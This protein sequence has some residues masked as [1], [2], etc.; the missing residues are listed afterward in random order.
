MQ[1]LG[2]LGGPTGWARWVNDAG[3][4]TGNADLPRQ[5]NSRP[6][7]HAFLWKNGS[8]TDLVPVEGALCS[9]GVSIN[10]REQV[11]GSIGNCRGHQLGAMLWE[12]GSAVDLNTLVAP[13][14]LHLTEAEYIS[15]RGEIVAFAVLPNSNQHVVLMEPTHRFATAQGSTIPTGGR[16]STA[17]FTVWFDSSA[18]GQG[19]VLFGS[20][21]GCS[22]LVETATQD[23]GAGTTS[24][25]VMVTGND[26]PGSV[27]D[28]G[29]MPG[30]TYWYEV[31]TVT[32]SGTEI[33]TNGGKC[34][35]VSIPATE[36]ER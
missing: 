10:N 33:D 6:T 31:A 3:E 15:D 22:G 30:V 27:G 2:T 28:N 4:V 25:T 8:M 18:P 16:S 19:E 13:S 5:P 23:Q 1:D 12:N 17:S 32:H 24:H 20:G 9:N 21:P 29:I 26:L 11:V 35:S 34:Y 14:A 36:R 7:H